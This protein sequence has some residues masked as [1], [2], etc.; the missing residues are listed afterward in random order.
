LQPDGSV[1]FQ[2][3][4]P[5]AAKVELNLEGMKDPLPM[6]KSADGTWTIAV[7]GLAPQYYS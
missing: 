5:N 4:M 2:L 7:P 1:L 3:S 6:T